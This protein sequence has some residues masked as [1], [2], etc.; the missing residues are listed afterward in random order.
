[1]KHP[2][3]AAWDQWVKDHP[4]TMDATTLDSTPEASHYLANRL[5]HAYRA[6]AEAG[7]QIAR[8]EIAVKLNDLLLS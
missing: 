1:M 6:G 3:S 2:L 4:E 5:W 7:R 8:D